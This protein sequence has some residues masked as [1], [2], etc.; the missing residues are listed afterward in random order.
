MGP[1]SDAWVDL[2]RELRELGQL[3]QTAMHRT[4]RNDL[5]LHPAAAGLLAELARR[6]E[7]RITELAH[8][9]MVDV[10]VISRQVA[11]LERVQLVERRPDPGDRRVALVHATEHGLTTLARWRCE[12]VD[13]LHQALGDWDEGAVRAAC[14]TLGAINDQLRR[15]LTGD[16]EPANP[17][18]LE[19][20]R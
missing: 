7:C 19:G 12:Q 17:D 8:R 18:I 4:W 20:A 10:S 2:V 6:G 14:A 15:S 11:Q 16:P 1:T 13:A 3:S 5:G 9:R